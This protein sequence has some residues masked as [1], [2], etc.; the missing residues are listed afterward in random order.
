MHCLGKYQAL[1]YFSSIRCQDEFSCLVAIAEPIIDIFRITNILLLLQHQLMLKVYLVDTQRYL[2][3]VG[4][5]QNAYKIIV[6]PLKYNHARNRICIILC[7]ILDK[8]DQDMRVYGSAPGLATVHSSAYLS[9][10][11]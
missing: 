3:G 11:I 4:C 9:V 7:C 1:R 5:G 2:N 6:F 8:L 10:V